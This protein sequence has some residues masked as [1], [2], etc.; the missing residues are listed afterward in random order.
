MT[1]GAGAFASAAQDLAE[2]GLAE[3][4][5]LAPIMNVG[6]NGAPAR[7]GAARVQE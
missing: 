4:I 7:R 2:A 6:A 3:L 5:E 1:A